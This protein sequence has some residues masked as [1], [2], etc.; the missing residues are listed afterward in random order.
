MGTM[1]RRC[2][3]NAGEATAGFEE[4]VAA[5]EADVLVHDEHG[6]GAG[7][8]RHADIDHGGDPGPER[9][10]RGAGSLKEGSR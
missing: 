9:G 2:W 1:H 4:Q 6:G 3:R 8:G 7:D 5:V 10:G